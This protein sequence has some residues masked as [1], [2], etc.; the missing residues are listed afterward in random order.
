M[1][2]GKHTN[3]LVRV[4]RGYIHTHT[5]YINAHSFICSQ[6]AEMLVLKQIMYTVTMELEVVYLLQCR[7]FNGGRNQ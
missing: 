5:K 4:V 3:K 2:H 1:Q 7:I 6:N